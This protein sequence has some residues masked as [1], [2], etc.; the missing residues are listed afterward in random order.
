MLCY[1]ALIFEYWCDQYNGMTITK[2][3]F[4]LPVF[5]LVWDFLSLLYF[6]EIPM[7]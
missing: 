1:S 2:T 5:K 4:N 6:Q 3:V 7:Y